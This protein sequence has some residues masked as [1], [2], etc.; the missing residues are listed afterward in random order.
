MCAWLRRLLVVA[1]VLGPLAA[2]FS[3]GDTLSRIVS[4]EDDAFAHTYFDSVRAGRVE[5]AVSVLSP[6]VAA[7]PGVRDSIVALS[8]Y[9]PAG[10]IDSMHL[11]GAFRFKS[12]S[13]DRTNFTYEYHSSAGWG[14][15][16]VVVARELGIRYVDAINAN[17]LK[18]SFEDANAFTLRGKSAGHYLILALLIVCVGASFSVAILALRT[19]MPR[20][21]LWALLALVGVSG[22][23]FNWTTGEAGVQL[24]TVQLFG[25]AVMRAGPAG[26]WFLKAAFPIG[27]LMTWR[28]IQQ[29]RQPAPTSDTPPSIPPSDIPAQQQA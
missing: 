12:S 4:P 11:V 3:S 8:K 29:A 28:R 13:V 14:A 16:S 21:W 6:R 1:I 20:R 26:P 10:P 18:R 25:G 5:F 19:P 2:C 27:A 9:L 15:A 23:T 17:R 22:L 24:L 7:F